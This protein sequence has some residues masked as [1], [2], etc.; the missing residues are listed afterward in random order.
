MIK[1]LVKKIVL[2]KIFI[3]PLVVLKQQGSKLNIFINKQKKNDNKTLN[4]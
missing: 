2:I 3:L 4:Q 1:F